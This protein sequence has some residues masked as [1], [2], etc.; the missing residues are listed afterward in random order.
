MKI[1]LTKLERDTI[2]KL[3]NE[4]IRS[5]MEELGIDMSDISLLKFPLNGLLYKSNF[6][7]IKIKINGDLQFEVHEEFSAK[8]IRNFGKLLLNIAKPVSDII[9]ASSF[10]ATEVGEVLGACKCNMQQ[11]LFTSDDAK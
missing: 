1:I 4:A 3:N 7:K 11:P 10:I 9:V 6:L 5:F 2:Q 8:F